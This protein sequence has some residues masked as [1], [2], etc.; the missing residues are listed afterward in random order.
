MIMMMMLQNSDQFAAWRIYIQYYKTAIKSLRGIDI[1]Y[2]KTAIKSL[3]DD[4][5]VLITP[6][7]Q[8]WNH[9]N[10]HGDDDDDDI[11]F[12]AQS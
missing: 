5:D 8:N 12:D 7:L 11:L 2:Y 10:F 1:Q 9:H 6:V 3:H 4:D